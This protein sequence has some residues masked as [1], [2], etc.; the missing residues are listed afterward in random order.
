[1]HQ[2]NGKIWK[3]I[4]FPTSFG[5][6]GGATFMGK[7]ASNKTM[8]KFTQSKKIDSKKDVMSQKVA[9]IYTSTKDFSQIRSCN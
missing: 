6:W 9:R 2:A 1:M 4:T 8:V 3:M 7:H 5:G